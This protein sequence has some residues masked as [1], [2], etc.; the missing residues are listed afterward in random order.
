MPEAAEVA[1]AAA[2]LARVAVGRELRSL[3][4]THPRTTRNV[5]GGALDDLVPRTVRSV[6]RHGK[7]LVVGLAGTDDALGIHLRMSGQLL[8]RRPGD[9]HPDR[10]VHAVLDLGPRPSSFWPTDLPPGGG[11]GVPEPPPGAPGVGEEPVEVWFRDPRTFGELR[12][13]PAGS[14]PVAADVLDPSVTGATLAAGAGRRRVGVK[15]VLLDQLRAVSGVGS[16][17]ADEALH[18]AGISPVRPADT[19]APSAWARILHELRS[20]ISES[21]AAGGVTLADEGW[22]D[23][24]GRPGRQGEALRVHARETCAGC[25]APTRSAVVGG[26]SAR[27]CPRC[28][29]ARR[30]R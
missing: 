15:A 28:Q 29:D 26:R 8:A 13:L 9:V 4:V 14:V 23:L 11:I 27:W 3:S 24:W 19:L 1:V 16:Y 12:V 7:W 25:G 2:Q 30:R 17:L 10:H 22:V 6:H 20:L 18:R 21:A 5:A